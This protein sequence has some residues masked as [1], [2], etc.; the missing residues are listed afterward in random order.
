PF[1]FLLPCKGVFPGPVQEIYSSAQLDQNEN[2]FEFLTFLSH[3]QPISLFA[4]LSP[5]GG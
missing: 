1:V 2:W 4:A 5:G 3:N